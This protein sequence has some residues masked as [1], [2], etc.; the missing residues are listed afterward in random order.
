MLKNGVDE[1]G[2]P[3]QSLLSL[4]HTLEGRKPHYEINHHPLERT[5]NAA[6][7]VVGGNLSL[8]YSLLGTPYD[9]DMSGKILF[10]EET[11]EF[12]YHTDRMM[13]SLRLAGKLQ[14]LKGLVVGQFSDVKDNSEPFGKEVEEIIYGAVADYTFP[15]CF[16]FPAGHD[17]I[18]LSVVFGKKWELSVQD[19]K[20]VV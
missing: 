8:L 20:S 4:M 17:A 19:R 1:T 13:N 15:V 6:A 14:D 18:N 16:G 7:S 3:V 5:G 11:G 9:I 12:L 2:N 10:I